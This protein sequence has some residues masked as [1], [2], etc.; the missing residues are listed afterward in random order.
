MS[1]YH[2]EHPDI[3]PDAATERLYER[4]DRLHDERR[5]AAWEKALERDAGPWD[6]VDAFAAAKEYEFSEE[7][8]ELREQASGSRPPPEVGH[9]DSHCHG[10]APS[11]LQTPA[12]TKP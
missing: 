8:R 10:T 4:A 1:R 6:R 3:E 9:G 5:D 2:R 12:N 11:P 7:Q